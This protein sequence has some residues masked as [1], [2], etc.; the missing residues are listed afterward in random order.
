[1][2]VARRLAA[3]LIGT[4]LTV[5]LVMSLIEDE[6]IP[7]TETVSAHP[8]DPYPGFGHSAS[9]ALRDDSLAVWDVY[10][11][12][13]LMAEC[14]A[15][16][17]FAYRPEAALIPSQLRGVLRYLDLELPDSQRPRPEAWNQRYVK[18]LTPRQTDAYYRALVGE[19]AADVNA[20][21][22]SGGTIPA[23]NT[24][25]SFMQGGCYG[26]AQK[27]IPIVWEAERSVGGW[28]ERIGTGVL[29]SPIIE[30]TRD[31][32]RDCMMEKAGVTAEDPGE[33]E[34]LIARILDEGAPGDLDAISNGLEGCMPI[35]ERGY[36][37]AERES[38]REFV[39]RHRDLLEVQRQ[40]YA[41]ARTLMLEDR[42]FI[43]WLAAALSS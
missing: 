11:Q 26:D 40:T 41:N 24:A 34:G 1:V 15:A 39:A 37:D 42:S 12:E 22:E 43:A 38:A 17:G 35:W 14:M 20:A 33:A 7:K 4:G 18:G 36:R 16:R 25:A 13:T 3:L 5:F 6:R 28:S 10:R 21:R 19:S 27:A 29:E 31:E 32:F 8:L 23:G 30:R 9:A 2:G